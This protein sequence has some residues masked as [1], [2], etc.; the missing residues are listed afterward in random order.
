MERKT[1]SALLALMLLTTTAC[2]PSEPTYA[3]GDCIDTRPTLGGD[4]DDSRVRDGDCADPVGVGDLWQTYQV[5]EVS[6]ESFGTSCP[7]PKSILTDGDVNYC[8]EIVN[9]PR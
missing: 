6:N 3:V 8:L 9:R 2:G 7:F 4:S 1:V 5:A